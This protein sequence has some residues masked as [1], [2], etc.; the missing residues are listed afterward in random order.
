M[1]VPTARALM[2]IA[3]ASLG[4]T[5]RDWALAMEGEFEASVEDGKPLAF[6]IGC[7]TAALGDLTTH[8][9]GRFLLMSYVVVLGVLLPLS[10]FFLSAFL[11]GFPFLDDTDVLLAGPSAASS[12]RSLLNEGNTSAA[13]ALALLVLALTGL[14]LL[15]GWAVLNR[16]WRQAQIM[17]QL[18]A[19][20]TITLSL[21][22]G[23]IFLEPSATLKLFIALAIEVAAVWILASWHEH[24]IDDRCA[25]A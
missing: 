8:R 14:L 23:V 25:A 3:A 9:E 18:S 24:L 4:K 10:A 2:N 6:A 19:S 11:I 21:F 22:T 15:V 16:N 1:I 12:T 20:A 5:R 17:V 13:P 7:L